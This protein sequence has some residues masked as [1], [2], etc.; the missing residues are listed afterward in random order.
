MIPLALAGQIFSQARVSPF[1]LLSGT[2]NSACSAHTAVSTLLLKTQNGFAAG[3]RLRLAWIMPI[4][5]YPATVERTWLLRRGRYNAYYNHL[6]GA[7]R[8]DSFLPFP[9]CPFTGAC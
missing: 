2:I 5:Q 6:V 3:H 9:L 8:G 1:T 4:L 7:A